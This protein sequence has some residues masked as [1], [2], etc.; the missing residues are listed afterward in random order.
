MC[1]LLCCVFLA[2]RGEDLVIE[3][4]L[5]LCVWYPTTKTQRQVGVIL[6]VG[7]ES[8]IVSYRFSRS[9]LVVNK[10]K[11]Y[12]RRFPSIR[13][14]RF[15]TWFFFFLLV[16]KEKE[17]WVKIENQRDHALG[18]ASWETSNNLLS[19]FLLP[20]PRRRGFFYARAVEKCCALSSFYTRQAFF[21]RSKTQYKHTTLNTQSVFSF[22]YKRKIEKR[23]LFQ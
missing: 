4:V 17:D 18:S 19:I 14:S 12:W 20:N 5:I 10:A 21:E 7:S 13:F 15:H 16:T 11:E 3:Y 8:K 9:M 6:C 2:Q 22:F 1:V 23:Y